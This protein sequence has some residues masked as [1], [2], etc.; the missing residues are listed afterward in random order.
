[1]EGQ[2]REFE[3]KR[4]ARRKAEEEAAARARGEG[5][6]HSDLGKRNE[7][8][9]LVQRK[10]QSP[11]AEREM[12]RAGR[13]DVQGEKLSAASKMGDQSVDVETATGRA[14][15]GDE[16]CRPHL[17]TRVCFSVSTL[18]YSNEV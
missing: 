3:R 16:H 17:M 9:S 11:G 8:A 12:K 5:E 14:I 7:E 13:E 18:G 4:E 10:Q 1:L 6:E 2:I 15:S